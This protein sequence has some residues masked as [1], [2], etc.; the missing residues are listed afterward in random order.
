LPVTHFRI[1]AL[2]VRAIVARVWRHDPPMRA[3]RFFLCEQSGR[4]ADDGINLIVLRHR[5]T[6]KN[7][8]GT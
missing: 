7:T 4:L 5:G 8:H 6:G 2:L 3:L 1:S